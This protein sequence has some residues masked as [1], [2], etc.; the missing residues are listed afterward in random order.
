[1][2]LTKSQNQQN[3]N[4]VDGDDPFV[5]GYTTA[6]D[7]TRGEQDA[8][9]APLSEFFSRPIKITTIQWNSL[10]SVGEFNPWELFFENP[11]VANRLANYNLLKATLKVKF[12][13]NGNA[14]L[15]GRMLVGY[16]PNVPQESLD[17]TTYA[18]FEDAVQLSQLPHIFL[19][20]TTS[21]GGVLTCP[22]FFSKNYVR[23]PGNEFQNL[24]VINYIALNQLLHSNDPSFRPVT[25]SVFAWAE[26]VQLSVLTSVETS[27]LIPQSGEI[28]EANRTGVVSGPASTV[29]RVANALSNIPAIRPYAKA[30]EL[31]SSTLASVASRFGYCR[32][33]VTKTPDFVRVLPTSSFALTNTP[34]LS[35]KL[36]VDHLQEATIDPRIAGIE[37]EDMLSIVNIAKRESYIDTFT[38][39]DTDISGDFLW[40]TRVTPVV[41]KSGVGSSY[42][43][44]ATAMAALPFRYW[45]G[46]L[47]YRF[48][49][50][51]SGFHKGRIAVAWDPNFISTNAPELNILYSEIIDIA[52]T[53]DFT[54]SVS[55][56]QQYTLIPNVLPGINVPSEVIST[57]RYASYEQFANGVLGIS[58][59]NALSTPTELGSTITVNVFI[60]AGDDFK[61][62]VPSDHFQN[63][64]V[65]T[66]DEE[67]LGVAPSSQETELLEPQSGD[68]ITSNDTNENSPIGDNLHVLFDADPADKTNLVFTGESIPSFRAMVKRYSLWTA[69]LPTTNAGYAN[70]AYNA[71]FA[72]FPYLR[73]RIFNAV[74]LTS[75][76]V[77]YNYCN[78]L[79]LH[80]LT[81]GFAGWRGNIRYKVVPRHAHT[82]TE[83][84]LSVE[85]FSYELAD[86]FEQPATYA[87]AGYTNH[88]RAAA[89]VIRQAATGHDTDFVV[90]G[91]NGMAWVDGDITKVLE[92][93][94]PWYTRHRFADGR[95]K[96]WTAADTWQLGGYY[97]RVRGLLN[98]QNPFDVYCAAGED[99][100]TFFFMG[101]PRMYYEP[102]APAA[103]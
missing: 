45:T 90:H 38:W 76:L 43:F 21:T 37:E 4:F 95:H 46:T 72:I 7:S 44:P 27:T 54:I 101:L 87:T 89:S 18:N 92:F 15:Y 62:F 14:F 42:H 57:T 8:E 3:V 48:Q 32:P 65:R 59:I 85:R 25:I 80:Y 36:S 63:F 98:N 103:F 96:S 52:E 70:I 1:M 33:S 67:V 35:L 99:F 79:L 64:V 77:Q 28:E 78:T 11:R 88:S 30:T 61:V 53:Q 29:A 24:G 100:Q 55:N 73:G 13:L 19:N 26:D 23:I 56:G 16:T 12:V 69:I 81:L 66:M 51:C 40:N 2:K 20:P 50:V 22:F 47:N 86:E 39:T 93:E 58:V 17:F 31:A 49:V 82:S 34:D 102:T 71:K 84:N 97:L 9:M 94:V 6:S 10:T 41:W 5:H 74:D 68:I 91:T 60:S 75:T 83:Y